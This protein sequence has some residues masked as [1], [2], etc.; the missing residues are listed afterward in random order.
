MAGAARGAQTL[1]RV[2]AV[3]DPVATHNHGAINGVFA[4]PITLIGGVA[5][6]LGPL[7]AVV[8]GSYA[9][10]ALIALGPAALSVA[11]VHFS[12]GFGR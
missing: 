3:A 9:A 5:P 10:T 7:R 8:T 1:G 11:S 4:A 6:A 12:E 2:S